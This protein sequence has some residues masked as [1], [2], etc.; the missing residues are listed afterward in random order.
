MEFDFTEEQL[1]IRTSVRTALEKE[2]PIE[3]V[4]GIV[5]SGER[6]TQP[7][8]TAVELGWPALMVPEDNDGLG[9]DFASMALVLEEHGRAVAPGPF[10]TTTTQF[11]PTMIECGTDAQKE[12]FLPT[13]A[14]GEL[15]GTLAISNE[16]G[17][18]GAVDDSMTAKRDGDKWKLN[19][20]RH[21]V[22]EANHSDEIIVSARDADGGLQLFVVPS[23]DAKLVKIE[24]FDESRSLCTLTLEA[25][26]ISDDRRLS[27][28]S[29]TQTGL[30]RALDVAVTALSLEMVGTCQRILD[31]SL[32]YAKE[33][34]QFGVAIGT[35][36]AI[37]HKFSD[38]FVLLEKARSTAYYATMTLA[39][40]DGQRRIAASMAK[41]AAGDC[42]KRMGKEG[43]QIHGGIGYTWEH[44]MH[45][46]VRRAKSGAQL[47]GTT[48]EHKIKV[49]ELI[50]ADTTRA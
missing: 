46:F 2:C 8:A 38:L 25:Y 3:L 1:E 24:S 4:R 23:S 13:L 20:Q 45:L 37:Q 6:P 40:D 7:W 42:Q 50:T 35:F 5:E 22:M 21:W 49:A 17:G 34:K 10:L 27:G 14:E 18:L 19:G 26:E 47:L 15:R 33:R 11:L 9:L 30:D 16:A 36:Q 31:V 28:A 41:A 48:S 43:I 32:E 29:D 39:E 12:K 44:N